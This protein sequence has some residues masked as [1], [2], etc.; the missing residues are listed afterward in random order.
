MNQLESNL[1]NSI[2]PLVN[3]PARYIGNE[4]NSIHHDFN[5]AKI[6]VALA[7]PD[8]YD[9]GMSHLG[10]KILYDIINQR[11]DWVAERVFAPWPDME[12][13][14]RKNQIPLYSLESYIPINRF[15][16]IGFSLQ[17]ELLYTNVLTMLDLSG[18]PI[19]AKERTNKDPIVIS[20]GPCCYNPE[21]MSEFIDAF[22]IGDG[23]EIIL[24]II[25]AILSAKSTNGSRE[26]ILYKLAE[27]EGIYVPVINPKSKTHNPIKIRRRY[28]DLEKAHYPV[29]QIVPYIETVHDRAAV[30]IQRGCT[31]GCRF[32]QTGFT[33][34]PRQERSVPTIIQLSEQTLRKTG[35]DELSLLS[36]STSDYSEI[37]PL[38]SQLMEIIEP[39]K[40][41][42]SLPSLRIDSFSVELANQI[43]KIRKTGFT[44][45]IEAGTERLRNAINKPISNVECLQTVEQVFSTGWQLVKLYLMLG[46]PTETEED[47]VGLVNLLKEVSKIAK[48]AAAKNAKVNAAIAPFIPK[49]HT[50]FQWCSQLPI[51]E[52]KKRIYW[53]DDQLKNTRIEL[54]WHD[55]EQSYLEAIFARGDR[56]LSQIIYTAWKKGAKFDSW[57]DHFSFSNWLDAF[58]ACGIN[59]DDYAL[60]T[61]TIN[62]TFPWDHINAG[63]SKEF[64]Y[65][66]Y[67]KAL[68]TSL[69]P[70]CRTEPCNQCGVSDCTS[71]NPNSSKA[72]QISISNQTPNIHPK[73]EDTLGKTGLSNSER[74]KIRIKFTKSA[75]VRFISHLDL[76]KTI[77]TAFHRAELPIAYSQGFNPQPRLS[78][79]SALSLGYTSTSEYLECE[80]AQYLPPLEFM[81]RFATVLPTGIKLLDS[82]IVPFNAPTLSSLTSAISYRISNL[83]DKIDIDNIA[84]NINRINKQSELIIQRQTADK[85]TQINIRPYILRI[86]VNQTNSERLMLDVYLNS[87]KQG[88]ARPTEVA[89]LL[90]NTDENTIKQLTIERTGIYRTIRGNIIPLDRV[91]EELIYRSRMTTQMVE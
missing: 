81:D 82:W 25:E 64:L 18:I 88:S 2:L 49:P 13:E 71:A 14:L 20:G 61:Y 38:I 83:S 19:W 70:D 15:D 74:W 41:S 32:C 34:R 59:P 29:Q 63:V 44:F 35:Y 66:E 68:E 7:F 23:E 78:F 37:V 12:A 91:G 69:T 90:L 31:R 9:I 6:R 62:D 21:P 79:A 89:A 17:H 51:I 48:S 50:P 5:Q 57:S 72:D 43:Q 47:L 58:R 73:T 76:V 67:Q 56:R 4:Y 22:A 87:T 1:F 28:V 80:I 40:I 77:I 39:R 3:K 10:L 30:E 24:E 54:K 85:I 33:S 42:L 45:A 8:V 26:Q 55:L 75:P 60:K 86:M 27:I 16:I 65:R 36:L 46:L 84:Q 52:L 53:I 11:Q